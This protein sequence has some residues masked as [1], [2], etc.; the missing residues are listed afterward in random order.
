MRVKYGCVINPISLLLQELEQ[1]RH[2]L[3]LKLQGC[4]AQWES[5]VG[6]LERDVRALNAH[7]E[8]LTRQLSEAEREK[9][10]SEEQHN[11]ISQQLQEQLQAVST[12][13]LLID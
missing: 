11:E 1:D 12:T 13:S 4:Q 9:G 7:T 5:Q 10:R 3:R 2:D 8:Q 6:E